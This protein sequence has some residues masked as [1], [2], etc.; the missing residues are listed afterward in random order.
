MH[1]Q[2]YL[3][4]W[5]VVLFAYLAGCASTPT[6]IANK[7]RPIAVHESQRTQPAYRLVVSIDD[8]RMQLMAQDKVIASYLVS[9][10]IHGVGEG[11][12]TGG[13]P[14]GRHAIAEKIGAGVPIG[15][16]FENRLPT[17]EIVAANTPGRWPVATRI[18][19]L[20]GLENKNQTTFERL[21]YLHGSPVESMLGS[22]ASGGC[23]RM[24]SSEIVELFEKI[25]VGTE[26]FVFE[27]SMQMAVARLLAMDVKLA[28]L[29]RS[30]EAGF[31]SA[32]S[33]LCSGHFYGV[34]DMPLNENAALKWCTLAAAQQDPNAVTLLAEIHEYGKGVEV[35]IAKAR[36]LY[37]RAAK[38]GHRHAQF[39]MAHMLLY[40]VGGPTDTA[41]SKQYLEL[42][43]EQ[44]YPAALSLMQTRSEKSATR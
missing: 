11:V 40:G 19:R 15:T 42:S 41:L 6:V 7:P 16:V 38:L 9:T 25:D 28:E 13:T 22:P 14:R 17:N 39:R 10:S 5:P 8:Q 29:R 3:I 35:S 12:D 44:G 34:S 1:I 31:F 27:E 37:E 4:A 32:S 43:A 24:R 20:Q 2:K 23:I 21:I 18:L 30:A 33:Q 26:L 36:T